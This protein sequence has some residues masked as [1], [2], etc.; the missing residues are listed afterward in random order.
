MNYELTPSAIKDVR[1]ILNDTMRM[2]GPTQ[3]N[4]YTALIDLGMAAVAK[5]PTIYGSSDYSELRMGIGVLHLQVVARRK[6]AAAHFIYY[7][8][9][10][11]RD[12]SDGV[13]ILRILHEHMNPKHRLTRAVSEWMR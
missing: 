8:A 9:G 1:G 10:R 5:N 13:V 6:G 7:R 3:F 4:V 11:L 12:G 2:F